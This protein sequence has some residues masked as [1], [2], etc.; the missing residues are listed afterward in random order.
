MSDKVVLRFC[1]DCSQALQKH[2]LCAEDHYRSI[3]GWYAIKGRLFADCGAE[4]RGPTLIHFLEQ[5]GYIAT[6]EAYDAQYIGVRP[7][8]YEKKTDEKEEVHC[9]CARQHPDKCHLLL[10]VLVDADDA[11]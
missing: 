5:R 4:G 8:G 9:F 7:I 10:E 11:V 2:G 6:T 1:H 3:C